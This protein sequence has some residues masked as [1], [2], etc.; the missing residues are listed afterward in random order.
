MTPQYE[1]ISKAIDY[2]EDHIKDTID[3]RVLANHVGFS[4]FYFSR[5]FREITGMNPYDYYR[6]RK[7]TESIHYMEEHACKIIDVAFEFGFNSPEVF[8]RSCLSAL[9]QSPSQI[10]KQ[11]LDKSFVGIQ[12]LDI[13]YLESFSDL[14]A[15]KPIEELLPSFIL[16]GTLFS[17]STLNAS[18]DYTNPIILDLIDTTSTLYILNWQSQEKS[19][20]YNHLVGTY[21]SLEQLDKELNSDLETDLF[22]NT[23]FKKIPEC[24]YL[25]FPLLKDGKELIHMKEYVYAH[26]LPN[27]FDLSTRS[28]NVE[29]IRFDSQRKPKEGVL[30]APVVRKREHL[31]KLSK[32]TT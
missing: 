21:I 17:S 9:G 2:I 31:K 18:L 12:P 11:L 29:A 25:N 22:K 28:F 10:R 30:Y 1:A 8:T 7:V 14:F 26:Y 16:K 15:I 20:S 13:Q 19:D 32:K 27:Q 23:V 5:L 3:M 24:L 6:G 4:K